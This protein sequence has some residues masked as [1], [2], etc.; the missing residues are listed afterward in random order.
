[1]KPKGRAFISGAYS[2]TPEEIEINLARARAV[3]EEVTKAGWVPIC[4][5][6]FWSPFAEYQDYAFWLD[7]A[8]RLLEVCDILIL[9]PGWEKSSGVARELD[10][11]RVLGIQ[12]L[13]VEEFTDQKY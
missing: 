13:T 3:S 12:I 9:V 5:N 1:M 6:I 4:P 7:A 2:G 11:A 10:R 8:L